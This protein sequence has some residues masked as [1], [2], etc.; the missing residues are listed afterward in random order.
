MSEA[1]APQ[2]GAALP[3]LPACIA[4]LRT[5]LAHASSSVR[6]WAEEQAESAGYALSDAAAALARARRMAEDVRTAL[7][8]HSRRGRRVVHAVE[9]VGEA[10]RR[11]SA[12]RDWEWPEENPEDAGPTVAD[13][14]GAL[15]SELR[16]ALA[17][18]E[19]A[20]SAAAA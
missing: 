16:R 13:L 7:P 17:T 8:S 19:R 11:V 15:A 6:F 1:T 14:R 4:G 9:Q 18:A 12:A 5:T 20:V 10:L 2:G 3:S